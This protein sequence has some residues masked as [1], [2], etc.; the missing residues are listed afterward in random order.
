V[1]KKRHLTKYKHDGLKFMQYLARQ[2]FNYSDIK[3]VLAEID[4]HDEPL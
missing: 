3:Q 4:T 1:A 2:G